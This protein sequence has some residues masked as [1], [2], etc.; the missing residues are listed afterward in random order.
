M[1]LSINELASMIELSSVKMDVTQSDIERLVASAKKYHC[2]C[3][4][5]LQSY[6]PFVKEL[7]GG[8]KEIS[9][10]SGVG[11]PS[12]SETTS[13]KVFQAKELMKMGC[14]DLDMVLNVGML[15]S[16]KYDYVEN[17]IKA[18]VD[19]SMD[20][21]VKVIIEVA[22]L[23]D[24]EIKRA[25]EACIKAGAD[26]VKTGTGWA[27][28]DTTT[29]HIKLIKSVVGDEIKIKA[30]GGVRDLDTLVKMHQLGSSSFGVN[31]K[32]GVGIIEEYKSKYRL[33]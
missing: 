28:K 3:I 32:C 16:G 29:Y 4:Y 27:K 6:I 20:N 11:Y 15:R 2:K 17:D 9:I 19:A 5:A 10:G 13:A 24:D 30:S 21:C 14:T 22:Y 8:N 33:K 26:Y 25:S 18:I 1:D 7:L 12:G 23:T 31:L